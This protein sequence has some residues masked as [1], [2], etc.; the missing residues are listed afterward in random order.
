[1]LSISFSCIAVYTQTYDL[2]ELVLASGVV[3]QELSSVCLFV[4]L[5]WFVQEGWLSPLTLFIVSTSITALGFL[6][7]LATNSADRKTWSI[8]GL[9]ADYVQPAVLFVF[10]LCCVSPVLKTLTESISTD[11]IWAM[12]VCG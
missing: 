7:S 9:L 6:A 5:Y 10:F 12:T 2:H 3:S 1:V 8:P 4:S 11:T